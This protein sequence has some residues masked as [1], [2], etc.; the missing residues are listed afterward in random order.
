M[1]ELRLRNV[2]SAT[3]ELLRVQAKRNGQTLELWLKNQ[4]LE[5]A[6]RPMRQILEDL[7]ASREE[8]RQQY[9]TLP[10]STAAFLEGREGLC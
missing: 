4:L 3:M 2:D 10:D 9:G 6:T 7:R 1:T 5:L 8:M